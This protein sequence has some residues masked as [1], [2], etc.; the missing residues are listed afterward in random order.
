M[1]RLRQGNNKDADNKAFT[2]RLDR[3]RQDEGRARE[4]IE[5][6]LEEERKKPPEE[7]RELRDLVTWLVLRY[8]GETALVST[9]KSNR[10]EIQDIKAML[11]DVL[12][13]VRNRNPQALQTFANQTSED[14]PLDDQFI[15]SLLEG[16]DK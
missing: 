15:D 12:N 1:P 7:R 8:S 2:F 13:E 6:W 14:A 9:S 5:G 4:L 10:N 16:W 11:R 3:R